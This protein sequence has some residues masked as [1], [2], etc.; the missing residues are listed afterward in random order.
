MELDKV[1]LSDALAKLLPLQFP[2]GGRTQLRIETD[3]P[4]RSLPALVEHHLLR[5]GQEAVANAVRHAGAGQILVRMRYGEQ[6]AEL[7][8]TDNGCGFDAV[9]A[10]A[11]A[12]GHFGL[13]GLRERANKLQ[14]RLRIESRP[15]TGTLVSVTLPLN[16]DQFHEKKQD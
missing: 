4:P 12:S 6:E 5:I 11:V 14:G 15:G 3:G 2:A 9:K 10:T 8:V 13:L 1:H 7:E 16:T